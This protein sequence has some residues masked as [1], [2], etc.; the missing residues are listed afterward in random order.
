ML[1]PS[2]ALST[3]LRRAGMAYWVIILA[4]M[5]S[6]TMFRATARSTHDAVQMIANLRISTM[7]DTVMICAD[8]YVALTVYAVF[9]TVDPVK[10]LFAMVFRLTQGAVIAGSLMLQLAAIHAPDQA[11]WLM[12]AQADGY[13]LGLLFF[14]LNTA[15]MAQLLCQSGL[16]SPMT[17]RVLPP[18]L[19]LS[20][21][22]YGVN[23]TLALLGSNFAE[24]LA[25]SYAIPLVSES[26]F[27]LWL[28]VSRPN[29]SVTTSPQR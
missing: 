16:L 4:G 26:F 2:P 19:M 25:P 17:K 20:A 12:A 7:L 8:I 1:T 29:Q 3:R 13:D 23:S 22:I 27:A 24:T 5:S 6:E 9:R 18:L 14:A 21:L 28:L 10:S 15:L 11:A